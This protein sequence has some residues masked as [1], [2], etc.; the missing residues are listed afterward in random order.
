MKPLNILHTESSL[1]WGGQEIRIIN[2][3]LGMLKRGH[4]IYI[5]TPKKSMIFNRAKDANITAFPLSFK[6][7]NLSHILKL[8]TL[9]REKR[10]DVVNTHSSSDSWIGTIAARLSRLK[11]LILR[12]RHLST[13]IG[14]NTLSRLIY[15]ILPD[16]VITTGDEIKQRM[17]KYNHFDGEKIFSIP[18]GIDIEH[19]NPVRVSASIHSKG[20][21]IGMVSV[22]RSWKGHRYFIEAV[23]AIL[24]MIPDSLFYIVGDGPQ[25]QNIKDMI[26]DLLLE[27][28]VFMLGHRFDIPEILASLDVIV[29]PSYAN[30]GVPQSILQAMAMEKP[31]VASDAGSIKEVIID[32]ETGFLIEPKNPE[33]LSERVIE[34]YKNPELRIKF[35]REGRRLVEKDYSTEKMLDKIESLY[36]RLLKDK[37]RI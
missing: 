25:F 29:H 33:Q 36:E 10:I 31:V 18:T 6:K 11:P 3:S 17:I 19:F 34:L 9:I 16:A 12:T 1:G 37:K 20:F 32:R 23:P 4:K 2:E 5:A 27:D 14:R 8:T 24:G 26:K 13:P 30:E 35:G 22:L 21:S 15:N 28:K 7:K